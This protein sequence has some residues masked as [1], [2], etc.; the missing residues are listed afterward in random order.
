MNIVTFEGPVGERWFFII[1]KHKTRFFNYHKTT[2]HG[3]IK[4][5]ND[6]ILVIIYIFV[7]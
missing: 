6:I 2:N 4:L 5:H 1:H 7:N 3:Y